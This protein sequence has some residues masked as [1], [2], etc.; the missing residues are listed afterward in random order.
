MALFFFILFLTGC[1]TSPTGRKQLKLLGSSQ[2][3][4][5]GSQSFTEL[6]KKQRISYNSQYNKLTL[7][8]SRR[9]L[10]AA[11]EDSGA[12]EVVV[13]EDAS[14]NAF[15][16][17]GKKIG[18]HT[19]MIRLAENEAQLA[20]VIG[21]EIGHVLSEHGNERVSQGLA[22]QGL[23]LGASLALSEPT[24]KNQ[25][26]LG[27]IGLGAQFGVLM[28]YSRKHEE[29]ADKLGVQYMAK[30]GFDPQEASRLWMVMEKASGSSIPEILSTH[31]S[32]SSRIKYLQSYA[33]GYREA[34][35]NSSQKQSCR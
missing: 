30:A 18:V 19:G 31:P 4:A 7:C 24:T 1:A 35:L 22:A 17:P 3:D 10:K 27:A 25:I 8:L 11:G 23:I 21:H 28:P 9:L 20:A 5:M 6:K 26:L 14:P 15:A 16:L 34:Y 29:E 2:M 32:S 12:W 33:G 13:F